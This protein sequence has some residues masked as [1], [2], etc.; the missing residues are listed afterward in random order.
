M[1]RH[2][3]HSVSFETPKFFMRG[4]SHTLVA[5]SGSLFVAAVIGDVGAAVVKDRL[6]HVG[7]TAVEALAITKGDARELNL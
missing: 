1:P 7:S 2:V 5:V 3:S 6:G 4:V